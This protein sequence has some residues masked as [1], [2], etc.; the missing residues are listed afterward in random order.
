M[1]KNLLIVVLLVVALGG[2]FFAGMHYQNTI[3]VIGTQNSDGSVT[4]QNVQINPLMMMRGV[5]SPTG[6]PTSAQ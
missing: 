5:V 6:V 4:A 3:M 2:G 1:N